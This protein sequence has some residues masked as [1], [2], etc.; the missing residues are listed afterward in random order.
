MTSHLYRFFPN[1]EN[2]DIKVASGSIADVL[3]Q[4]ES[5]APGIS[6]Y[7]LDERRALRRHVNICIDEALIIDKQHLS[8]R[9]EEGSTVFIFQALSGG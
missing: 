7:V 4:L 2:V 5:L 6:D 9:V 8:D 1:L 3:T